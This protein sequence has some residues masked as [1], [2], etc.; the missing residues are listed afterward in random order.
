MNQCPQ[1]DQTGTLAVK[2]A[3]RPPEG[4][5]PPGALVEVAAV[6]MWTLT[7]TAC[8]FHTAG[9]TNLV[10]RLENAVV[11]PV[12]GLYTGGRVICTR[13]GWDGP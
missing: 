7:C 10:G 8:G 3:H 9:R 12:T 5:P 2:L 6:Q 4:P 13:S 11:D 1:C